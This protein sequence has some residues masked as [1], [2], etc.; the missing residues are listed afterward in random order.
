MEDLIEQ[1]KEFNFYKQMILHEE[2]NG[3]NIIITRKDGSS[4][5]ATHIIKQSFKKRKAPRPVPGLDSGGIP[6]IDRVTI[7][8]DGKEYEFASCS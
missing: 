4:Y 2:T 6:D 3:R 1:L 8:L 5:I 7:F